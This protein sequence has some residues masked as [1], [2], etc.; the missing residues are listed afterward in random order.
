MEGWTHTTIIAATAAAGA[1]TAFLAGR[2]I[3]RWAESW[4]PRHPEEVERLRRREISRLGR[5]ASA[6]I[7]DVIDNASGP[8]AGRVIIYRYEVAGVKYEAAQDVSA[9]AQRGILL[10][11]LAGSTSSVKYDPR[12]PINSIIACEEWSGIR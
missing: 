1:L 12:K 2:Q 7:V 4:R 5:I 3:A 8:A 9:F 10:E 6:E 11:A